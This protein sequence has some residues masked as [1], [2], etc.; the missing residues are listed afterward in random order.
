MHQIIALSMDCDQQLIS[1]LT[2]SG[3][4]CFKDA[5]QTIHPTTTKLNWAKNMWNGVIYPSETFLFSVFFLIKCIQ[6]ITCEIRS[7][8]WSHVVGSTLWLM[9]LLITFSL[10]VFLILIYRTGCHMSCLFGLTSL[11]SLLFLRFVVKIGVLELG[12]SSC[13]L[14][15]TS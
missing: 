11:Q 5:C 3:I 7:V 6:I 1:S 8:W 13:L 2:Y 14:L 12:T 4:L 9:K 10:N 15:F